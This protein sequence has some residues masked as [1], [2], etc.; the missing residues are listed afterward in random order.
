MEAMP[1]KSL[2]RLFILFPDPW[3]KRRHHFR[4]IIHPA[5]I[6]H[7]ARLLK[8]GSFLRIACDDISYQNWILHYMGT[9]EA[10]KWQANSREGWNKRPEDALPTR[11]EEKAHKMGRMPAFLEFLRV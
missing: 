5:T 7:F 6:P 4:R 10:F 2:E 8:E 9:S 1:D 3:H 11:Y